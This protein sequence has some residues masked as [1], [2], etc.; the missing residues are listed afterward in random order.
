MVAVNKYLIA[1]GLLVMI[2]MS[3]DAHSERWKEK[4]ASPVY[5][6]LATKTLITIDA[7]DAAEDGSEGWAVFCEG[8]PPTEFHCANQFRAYGC[9]ESCSCCYYE[10]FMK[11]EPQEKINEII[12]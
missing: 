5:E 3:L 8:D 6:L 10:E 9:S 1:L 12:Q 4:R 2:L 7:E 11:E